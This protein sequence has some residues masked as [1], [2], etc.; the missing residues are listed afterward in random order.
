M[1][2]VTSSHCPPPQRKEKKR[3]SLSHFLFFSFSFS[4]F[5][6]FLFFSSS[7]FLFLLFPF[8]LFSFLF[9]AVHWTAGLT[10]SLHLTPRKMRKGK[11][12]RRKG[13][14]P[15]V[16]KKRCEGEELAEEIV[17]EEKGKALEK[18]FEEEQMRGK[19]LADARSK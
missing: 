14:G 12:K 6:F 5:L 10:T 1:R 18:L 11:S 4:L 17:L 15:A 19:V 2:P 7:P 13:E 9:T 16:V 3:I 8:F